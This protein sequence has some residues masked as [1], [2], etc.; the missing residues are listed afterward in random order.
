[1]L[2]GFGGSGLA[3]IRVNLTRPGEA[4]TGSYANPVT[5]ISGAHSLGP[6]Y[7]KQSSAFTATLPNVLSPAITYPE[8]PPDRSYPPEPLDEPAARQYYASAFPTISSRRAIR[9][10]PQ[11]L[12]I[13]GKPADNAATV[14]AYSEWLTR[15]ALP[16][17][18]F[19]A[20]PGAAITEG[21]VAWSR[22]HFASLQTVDIGEGLHFI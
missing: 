3:N 9:Q 15:S 11:E 22:E 8:F 20:N 4:P 10:W 1:M 16:K 6:S 7:P 5:S 21:D 12:P 19:H 14:K 18:L 13:G 17:I 2:F